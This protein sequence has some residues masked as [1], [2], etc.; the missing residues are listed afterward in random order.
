MLQWLSR[1]AQPGNPV[2]VCPDYD[3]VGVSEFMRLRRQCGEAARLHV[4][5]EIDDLF[6][7]YGKRDL[8]RK[9]TGV[10]DKLRGGLPPAAKEIA[11][12]IEETGTG[13]EQEALI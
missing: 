5:E 13:L 2:I 6:S 9:S 4:P 8:Y 10:L 11:H 1:T 7:R 12:L 3:P